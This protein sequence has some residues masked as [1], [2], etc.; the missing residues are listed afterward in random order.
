MTSFSSLHFAQ[1]GCDEHSVTTLADHYVFYSGQPETFANSSW[2]TY[3]SNTG[4]FPLIS[5]EAPAALPPSM[6]APPASY[7][8]PRSIQVIPRGSTPNMHYPIP[9]T[10]IHMLPFQP[11]TLERHMLEP[12]S[13]TSSTFDISPTRRTFFSPQDPASS[14]TNATLYNDLESYQFDAYGCARHEPPATGLFPVSAT[15]ESWSPM[16]AAPPS[17]G[18]NAWDPTSSPTRIFSHEM[19]RLRTAL[20]CDRCRL[21]KAKVCHCLLHL[22]YAAADGSSIQCTGDQPEC[23]RCILKGYICHYTPAEPKNKSANRKRRNT[24]SGPDHLDASDEHRQAMVVDNHMLDPSAG[25]LALS[26]VGPSAYEAP[27]PVPP[28][29]QTAIDYA[30][31]RTSIDSAYT[32]SS[33][34]GALGPPSRS[35]P[36]KRP[37]P[38]P[39]LAPTLEHE[40]YPASTP[41]SSNIGNPSWNPMD[42]APMATRST[43]QS[44]TAPSKRKPPPLQL[45]ALSNMATRQVAS[46]ISPLA[47]M[48]SSIALRSPVPAKARAPAQIA[49][50]LPSPL[51]LT[52]AR[53]L[54][55]PPTQTY[56]HHYVAPTAIT[57]SASIPGTR[58]PSLIF[59]GAPGVA[60][61]PL[62]PGF[63]HSPFDAWASEIRAG[64]QG[65]LQVLAEAQ[66]RAE[67]VVQGHIH[68]QAQA[69]VYPRL[70]RDPAYQPYPDASSMS[71]P[72]SM[73][74]YNTGARTIDI[75][76]TGKTGEMWSSCTAMQMQMT[77]ST[78]DGSGNG[79][80]SGN[81]AQW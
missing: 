35:S 12:S 54:P 48:F 80:G 43:T 33:L 70:N 72:M 71:M 25:L 81:R 62:T 51:P 45:G 5:H 24:V 78:M 4:N 19:P 50:L 69:Q 31:R 59:S 3:P 2:D 74:A 22:S 76:C 11:P 46:G 9:K 58:P 55:V 57:A 21:R 68:I 6:A 75:D 52:F 20:A 56:T 44:S 8:R 14:M 7:R 65:Q 79:K 23:S 36:G 73:D 53:P 29:P 63:S 37:L 28:L 40:E 41:S 64:A 26:A 49:A 30:S 34:A 32:E 15:G 61:T 38:L 47:P 42:P 39:T 18:P 17:S 27:P 10:P 13:A 66:P 67:T 1:P 60:D 77:A 16:F